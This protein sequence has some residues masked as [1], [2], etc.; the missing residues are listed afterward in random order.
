L[1]LLLASKITGPLAN[2]PKYAAELGKAYETALLKAGAS[3]MNEQQERPEPE[4]E[5]ITTRN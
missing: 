4:S 5:F 2:N 3:S 1:T